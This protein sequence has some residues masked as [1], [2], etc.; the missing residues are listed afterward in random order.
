[1]WKITFIKNRNKSNGDREVYKLFVEINHIP[2]ILG[3]T[4]VISKSLE[5]VMRAYFR[6]RESG[7][8]QTQR[9]YSKFDRPT[10]KRNS[11]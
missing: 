3:I 6:L 2:L 11:E 8:R 1:M 10:I 9:L 4:Q 7:V 5:S